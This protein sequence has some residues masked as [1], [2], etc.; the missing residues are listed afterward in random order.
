MN[1]NT[2]FRT[3]LVVIGLNLLLAC[4]VISS[5]ASYSVTDQQIEQ[6]L[7]KQIDKLAQK[8]SVA[9]IPVMLEVNDL[10]V[11]VGPEERPVVALAADAT[12]TVSVFGLAYPAKVKLGL[13]GEPYYN[14]DEKALYVRS[15]S[16]THSAIDAAGFRGNLAPLGDKYMGLFNRYLDTHPV[17]EIDT[18]KAGLG[19]LATMPLMM[20]VESGKIVFKPQFGEDEKPQANQ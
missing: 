7:L 5:V 19:W 3:L 20:K 1:K 10:S 18:S 6:V 8:T 13:E 9:G 17:Y 12:A 4:S 2:W 15:L 16:L 11:I 14:K